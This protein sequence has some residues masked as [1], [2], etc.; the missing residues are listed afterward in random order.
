MTASTVSSW[1]V[2]VQQ[3]IALGASLADVIALLRS[4]LGADGSAE[5]LAEVLAGWQKAKDE[6]EA[7]I[8]ELEQQLEKNPT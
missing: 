1:L 4:T 7:R 5:V 2:T 8:K 6:N 3:L